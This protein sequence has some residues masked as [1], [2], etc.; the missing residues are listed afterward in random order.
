MRHKLS[1]TIVAMALLAAGG[2]LGLLWQEATPRQQPGA[3]IT[4]YAPEQHDLYDGRFV[5]GAGRIYQVGTLD[6]PP[7]WD[8]IDN[9]ASSARAVEGTVEIDVNEIANTG[10]FRAELELPEGRLV[11][12]IDRFNE[13]SPCQHGGI[14]AYLYEHGDSGCGDTNWPKS[15][16]WLA[17]WGY[18]H[19]T[20]NGEP[21][22]D[23]YQMHFMVTQGM[24]DRETLRVDYPLLDKTSP[25]GA[26]NPAAQQLDFYI[27]SPETDER[28]NPPRAVFAHFFAME[29]TWR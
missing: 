8:H 16:L 23:D 14:A 27:R 6:D 25:A 2:S 18:G 12:A 29:V 11:L 28:N 3:E 9:D 19:A 13:F 15:F 7:G 5:L 17:G 20:L 1:P 22:Y 10:T 21:L 4:V 26:V 24:R